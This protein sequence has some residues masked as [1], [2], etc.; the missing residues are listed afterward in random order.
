MRQLAHNRILKLRSEHSVCA[1]VLVSVGLVAFPLG[2]LAYAQEA[3]PQAALGSGADNGLTTFNLNMTEKEMAEHHAELAASNQLPS[4]PHDEK[5][6]LNYESLRYGLG[7]GLVQGADSAIEF[8]ASGSD[9][10]TL[11]DFG[12][13]ATQGALGTRLASQHLNLWNHDGGWSLQAGDLSSEIWGLVHGVSYSLPSKPNR[14]PAIA[15]VLVNQPGSPSHF[16]VTYRDSIQLRN[17]TSVGGE[18]D[19]DRSF[20]LHAQTL[21]KR[22]SLFANYQYKPM[23]LSTGAGGSIVYNLGRGISVYGGLNHNNAVTTTSGATGLGRSTTLMSQSI[24]SLYGVT[25]PLRHGVSLGLEQSKTTTTSSTTTG[26]AISLSLPAGR[27]NLQ[28]R[29]QLGGVSFITSPDAP[30]VLFQSNR[31]L[32]ITANYSPRRETT[33]SIQN[34]LRW[35]QSNRAENWAQVVATFRLARSYDLQFLSGFPELFAQDRMRV[36]VNH[37]L[38]PD[39]AMSLEYGRLM[40]Y[41]SVS[42]V[43]SSNGFMLMLRSHWI[44]R[45]PAHGAHLFGKVVD[46][47]GKPVKQTMIKIGEYKALTNEKG[48]YDVPDIPAGS[49]SVKIDQEALSADYRSET[50]EQRVTLTGRSR[51]RLDFRVVPLRAIMGRVFADKNGNGRP[52]SGEGIPRVVLRLGDAAT[53]TAEDGTFAFYNVDPGPHRIEID[54]AKLP[55]GYVLMSSV[56]V[57]VNLAADG[58]APEVVFQIEFRDR[59]IEFQDIK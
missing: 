51:Q 41:Q 9:A 5:L 36:R 15:A 25:V 7:I 29:Y 19:S 17:R 44:E 58:T 32:L 34:S 37:S 45:T 46:Q 6:P 16:A 8:T 59:P 10:G 18:I 21:A 31:T 11:V 48:E 43:Q 24:S 4:R 30:T 50:K 52:D 49:Y 33:L 42:T 2:R 3:K 14:S 56:V 27:M 35:D 54:T 1:W 26:T 22:L 20:L 47:T 38:T 55:T 40:P 53:A 12:A 23:Q 28:A 13:F 39:L 57:D